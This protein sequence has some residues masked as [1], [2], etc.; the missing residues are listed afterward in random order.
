VAGVV[1]VSVTAADN[2]GVSRVELRV[3]GT[4]VATDTASPFAFN[5]DSATLANGAAS[6]VAVAFDSAG[7]NKAS[8]AVSVTIANADITLPTVSITSPGASASVAGVVPVSVTAADNVGVTK[9][10]LRIN[11]TTVATDTT[12]PF[13][14]NWDSATL[15]NGA[16]SLVAVAFDAAGNSRASTPVTVTVANGPP[17]DT[18]APV[19]AFSNPVNGAT[20]TGIV[21]IR[22]T[23]TDDRPSSGIGQSL[24]I[25]D[26]L[27]ASATGGSLS[28][29]W[30][31][32]R[33]APGT[34][35]NLRA[36][37]WDAAGNRS[38]VTV[39]VK[40]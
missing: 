23:A 34:S 16:A 40:R 10:E 33:L 32:R 27:V 21:S 9:V 36:E 37:A 19:I 18:L 22:I 3:N 2:V 17:P 14:F 30:N 13:A 20:V 4:T 7:N 11:G 5:W 25:N 15:A 8:T 38:A 1:P 26:R 12:A 24:F 28:Y 6:L 35:H 29:N 31:A 39:T